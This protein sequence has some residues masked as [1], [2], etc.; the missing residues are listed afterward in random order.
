MAFVLVSGSL[1]PSLELVDWVLTCKKDLRAKYYHALIFANVEKMLEL[2]RSG[3]APAQAYPMQFCEFPGEDTLEWAKKAAAQNDADGLYYV[4]QCLWYGY[5]GQMNREFAEGE[6]M[7]QRA[8]SGGSVQA[9]I[10]WTERVKDSIE[11]TELICKLARFGCENMVMERTAKSLWLFRSDQSGHAGQLF[12]LGETLKEQIEG[13][14]VFGQDKSKHELQNWLDGCLLAV[15]MF[16]FWCQPT[17][18]AVVTWILCA[19]FRSLNKDV[20]RLIAILV[21]NARGES[22]RE[23]PEEIL[24]KSRFF[25]CEKA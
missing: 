20:R 24:E 21:W 5:H 7:L 19:K 6:K 3:Y 8:M 1:T 16:D 23:L 4:H 25:S 9:A 10:S 2:A 13:K 17:K 11:E 22:L 15:E 18:D 14:F 12:L